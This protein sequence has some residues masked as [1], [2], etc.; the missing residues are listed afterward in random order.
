MHPP[1]PGNGRGARRERPEECLADSSR[2]EDT[3]ARALSQVLTIGRDR[4]FLPVAILLLIRA[5][6]DTRSEDGLIVFGLEGRRL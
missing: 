3:D 6:S 4:Q 5:L 2:G 1:Q